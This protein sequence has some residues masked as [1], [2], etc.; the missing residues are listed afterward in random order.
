MKFKR[1]SM[2]IYVFDNYDEM[3]AKCAD[4]IAGQVNLKPDSI[5]GLATGSTP[6]GTYKGLIKKCQNGEVDFSEVKTFNLDEYYPIE[7]T[8]DQS[9]Y[10]FMNEQLFSHINIKKENVHIPSG[11]SADIEKEAKNYDKMME[12][13]AGVDIQVLGVGTNGHIGFNEPDDYFTYG[14]HKVTLDKE[15]IKS[16]ARFFE[17]E[18]MV[19]T[20][21]I[22]MGIGN[23][24]SSR[25][26]ILLASGANKA[27]AIKKMIF[28]HVDPRVPA[29]ILQL[30][31]DVVVFLDKESAKEI[32]DLL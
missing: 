30:H 32:I 27:D 6:I 28:G 2:T 21:A 23:I 15:T 12:E 24:M 9:Y 31:K 16:N 13:S 14:T 17:S 18:D 25:K 4:L 22:S 10:Y 3:S 11:N 7:P 29:S 8:N 26:I 1:G 5:L 19:P 20:Q